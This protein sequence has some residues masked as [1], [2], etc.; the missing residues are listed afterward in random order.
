MSD[1]HQVA[2]VQARAMLTD[3]RRFQA[4]RVK[5]I[6]QSGR[7]EAS[8]LVADARKAS[9]R[10]VRAAVADVRQRLRDAARRAAARAE[11]QT[12][13]REQARMGEALRQGWTSLGD[14]LGEA[15]DDPGSRLRWCAAAFKQA[16]R[17]M[18]SDNWTIEYPQG[19]DP[20]AFASLLADVGVAEVGYRACPDIRA[21]LRIFADGA[22]LDATTL[23]L[24]ANQS[25]VEARLLAHYG[26]LCHEGEVPRA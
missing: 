2:G 14:L 16:R 8:K 15:W 23:G 19:M 3:L 9:R 1:H 21:G 4:E 18:L 24:L 6:M 26:R 20:Q 10:R 17:L 25:R 13:L 22:C 12:R 7:D 5:T 11:T